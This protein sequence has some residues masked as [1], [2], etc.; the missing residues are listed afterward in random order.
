MGIYGVLV[1]FYVHFHSSEQAQQW[2]IEQL[3]ED[4][5]Y[6]IEDSGFQSL[7][8][9]NKVYLHPEQTSSKTE[10]SAI[11]TQVQRE[12]LQEH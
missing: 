7:S 1:S 8:S 9:S 5:R 4:A 10:S 11:D 12:P 2:K 3:F 6:L